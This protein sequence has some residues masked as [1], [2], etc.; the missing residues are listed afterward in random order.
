MTDIETIAMKW[1]GTPFVPHA[2][3]P[4]AGVDCVHLCGEILQEAGLIGDYS[5]PTY[6][7]DSGSHRDE[8]VVLSWLN[9]SPAFVRTDGSRVQAGDVL[10]FHIGRVAHHVGLALGPVRFIHALRGKG[11]IVSTLRDP[12]Y[13]KRFVAAYRPVQP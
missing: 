1:K 3:Q 9:H 5:F 4:G 12:T 8:S 2:A 11:V 13:A 7:C 6:R 10:C